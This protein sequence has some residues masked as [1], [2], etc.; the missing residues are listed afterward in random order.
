MLSIVIPT[1]NEEKNIPLILKE[2]KKISTKHEI[3]FVD[4]N[5]SDNS[6]LVIKKFL[7]NKIRFI[8]RVNKEKDL[9]KSVM[10]GVEKAKYNNVLIL[11]CDLQHNI[12]SA[13]LLISKF[14]KE[15][16]DIVIGSRFLKKK[17]SGNLGFVRTLFSLFFI[18]LI[19]V[20]FKKKTSDPLSGFFICKKNLILPFKKKFYL[21]GYKILFDIIYN[22]NKN[23]KTADIQIIFKK[24]IYGKSKLNFKIVITFIKQCLYSF[25]R[26]NF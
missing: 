13:N 17:Y 16:K 18:S 14:L 25:V 3:I 15:K 2:L 9:S 26:V 22:G 5:S 1:L 23:I 11:D 4:D 24:R 8:K 10:L 6:D 19:N 12:N 7:N 20:F 21:K